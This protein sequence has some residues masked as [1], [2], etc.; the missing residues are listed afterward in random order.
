MRNSYLI[1]KEADSLY[2]RYPKQRLLMNVLLLTIVSL[3][4]AGASAFFG[5][6]IFDIVQSMVDYSEVKIT[7]LLLLLLLLVALWFM[8]RLEKSFMGD[9]LGGE[10]LRITPG[11]IEYLK[12]KFFRWKSQYIDKQ[13][14]VA[15]SGNPGNEMILKLAK[16]NKLQND[17]ENVVTGGVYIISKTEVIIAFESLTAWESEDIARLIRQFQG[18]K[19][20]EDNP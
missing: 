2:V 8:Y 3:I 15:V 11:R 13:D 5:Y 16:K 7:G 14:L 1:R 19:N 9:V 12:R 10:K 20:L 17:E 6:H 18:Y 4:V